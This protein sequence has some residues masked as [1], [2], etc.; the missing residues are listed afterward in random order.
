MP[1]TQNSSV[2]MAPFNAKTKKPKS[3]SNFISQIAV[4]P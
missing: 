4:I 2:E 1:E 3:N